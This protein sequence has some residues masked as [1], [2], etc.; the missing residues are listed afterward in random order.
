MSSNRQ[1]MWV[2][3]V[4]VAVSVAD[5]QNVP[6]CGSNLVACAAFMNV[7]KPP[8]SC[9]DPLKETIE[10]QLQCLCNIYSTPG[11]LPSLGINVTEALTLPSRCGI[12][13]DLS[14]C[15]IVSL[16]LSLSF[17]FSFHTS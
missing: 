8:A 1:W 9:C 14:A 7:T 3:A 13:G 10:T 17:F 16:S 5:A 4:A 11:L 12:A 2:V 15:G 6:S